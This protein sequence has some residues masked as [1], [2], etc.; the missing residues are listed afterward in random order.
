MDFLYIPV[1]DVCTYHHRRLVP[2]HFFLFV[3]KILEHARTL[4]TSY[5]TSYATVNIKRLKNKVF[6]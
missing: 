5:F 3:W 2:L 4:V 6:L 1:V